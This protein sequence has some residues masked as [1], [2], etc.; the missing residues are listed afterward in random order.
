MSRIMSPQAIATSSWCA[1]LSTAAR[2]LA[3]K[4]RDRAA[5][6]ESM[7]PN[8]GILLL[9]EAIAILALLFV[10]ATARAQ[11]ALP[12]LLKD[13]GID[14]NL[15]AQVRLNLAFH[16]ET[17]QDVTLANY[18]GDKPVVLILAYYRCPMLCTQVLNG[19][20]DCLKA[21]DFPLKLGDDFRIVTVSFD[22]RE[23]T[24]TDLVAQKKAN[25]MATVEEFGHPHARDGW[26]FLTGEQAAID[27]LA[28]TVGFRYVHDPKLD[29]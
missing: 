27:E 28:R 2:R 25:Y 18:F 29:Q 14:Q 10:G 23:D 22:P 16:D 9:S 19:V 8:H 6:V 13:V 3:V 21:P 20:A 15:G 12:A 26:H 1:M 24:M 11:D 17:G 5:A 7:P 4:V